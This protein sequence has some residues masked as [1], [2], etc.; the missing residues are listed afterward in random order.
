MALDFLGRLR[1]IRLIPKPLPPEERPNYTI[2][3]VHTKGL[4]EIESIPHFVEGETD[5]MQGKTP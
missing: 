3:G 2:E 1:L 4:I 5:D